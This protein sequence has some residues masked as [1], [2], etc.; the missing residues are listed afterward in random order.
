MTDRQA[1]EYPK[2]SRRQVARLRKLAAQSLKERSRRRSLLP[3][4]PPPRYDELWKEAMARLE[5]SFEAEDLLVVVSRDLRGEG[6]RSPETTL[7]SDHDAV[8]G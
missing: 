1:Q 8:D 7:R 6:E 2:L 4:D 5:P 3:P